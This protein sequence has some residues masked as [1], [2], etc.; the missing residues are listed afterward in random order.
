MGLVLGKITVET[1]TYEVIRAAADYQ[2]SKYFLRVVA[3]VNYDASKF[4]NDRDG[5][6]IILANYIGALGDPQ[7]VRPEKIAMTAAIV[8]KDRPEKIDMTGRHPQRRG[9]D[10]AVRAAVQVRGGGGGAGAHGRA[11]GGEEGGGGGQVRGGGGEG[12]AAE[13]E[14]RAGRPQ[15]GR[16]LPPRQ[17]QPALDA[18]SR[19]HQRSHASRRIVTPPTSRSSSATY[20]SN[21]YYHGEMSVVTSHH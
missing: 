7:N 11:G 1:P 9:G 6:F 15:G 13:A 4:R 21:S 2:I 12:A 5:G 19:P 3:E 20:S 8:S 10:D 18:A 17:V 16:R 14:L